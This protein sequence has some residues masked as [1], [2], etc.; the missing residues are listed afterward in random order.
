MRTTEEECHTHAEHPCWGTSLARKQRETEAR[1]RRKARG[2]KKA[3]HG[4]NQVVQK[5]DPAGRDS[6]ENA[7]I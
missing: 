3:T 7:D 4:K 5:I 6:G 2:Q 1:L